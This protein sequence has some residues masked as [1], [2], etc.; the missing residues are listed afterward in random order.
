M[1]AVGSQ[2]R[3]LTNNSYIDG[4]PACSPDGDHIAF[5]SD[6]DGDLEIFVLN[7]D[8]GEERQLTDNDSVEGTPVWSP[9]G[10]RIAFASERYGL[11]WSD[12]EIFVMDADGSNVD[13]T[14]QRGWPTSW[15]G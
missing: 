14:G 5:A 10:D 9:D 3:Q 6:R 4:V 7:I 13:P 1:D 15:G 12:T 11:A 8:D 2:H